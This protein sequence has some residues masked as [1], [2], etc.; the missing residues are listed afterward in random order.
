VYNHSR[1]YTVS[2][3]QRLGCHNFDEMGLAKH[4]QARELRNALRQ[5]RERSGT[6]STQPLSV[7]EIST[8]L[9]PSA[10]GGVSIAR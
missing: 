3:I 6:C 2:R 7:Q 8:R 4:S 9:V 1:S 10:F 5:H